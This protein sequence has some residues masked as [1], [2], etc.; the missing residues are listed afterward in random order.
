MIS[1]A[2]CSDTSTAARIGGSAS[3]GIVQQHVQ[4]TTL[5][6]GGDRQ[7][8]GPLGRQPDEVAAFL[9][10]G[11]GEGCGLDGRQRGAVTV[12][13]LQDRCAVAGAHADESV[14]IARERQSGDIDRR[15]EPGHALRP[16]DGH[17][18]A[19][20]DEH[21]A[22]VL[23]IGVEVADVAEPGGGHDVVGERQ[24]VAEAGA[25]VVGAEGGAGGPPPRTSAPACTR[26]P[27][28]RSRASSRP[29]TTGR[30]AASRGSRR[31]AGRPACRRRRRCCPARRSRGRCTMAMPRRDGTPGGWSPGPSRARC[32]GLPGRPS[33]CRSRRR[34]DRRSARERRRRAPRPARRRSPCAGGAPAPS[35]GRRPARSSHPRR[36][37]RP[38]GSAPARRPRRRRGQ[39]HRGRRR[40]RDGGGA[41]AARRREQPVGRP[42]S[43]PSRS[44]AGAA[45]AAGRPEARS[46]TAPSP[47]RGRTAPGSPT[48]SGRPG[49]R[50]PCGPRRRPRRSGPAGRSGWCTAPRRRRSPPRSLISNC[51]ATTAGTPRP[52]SVV[53]TP[54]YGSVSVVR[55]PS[56]E[57]STTSRSAV[58]VR[59]QVGEQRLVDRARPARRRPRGTG[60]RRRP[61]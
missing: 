7:G 1:A 37:H 28:G 50:S 27:C 12:P 22:G 26:P 52:I 32:R 4:R 18:A 19:R 45:A 34:P 46:G 58:L 38:A 30:A 54:A 47:A 59:E 24:I 23:G 11:C 17:V 51:I 56:H 49:C 60:R 43:P 10:E 9:G 44:P 6:T 33:P 14:A 39:P 42:S 31:A 15:W 2:P 36:R 41:E 55:A 25:V 35:A 16:G 48:R 53:A 40:G 3:L 21:D 8:D 5:G 29:T 61:P 57:L 20:G 13:D